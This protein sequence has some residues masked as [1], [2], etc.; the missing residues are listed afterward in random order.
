MPSTTI[1]ALALASL[2]ILLSA[3]STEP[4]AVPPPAPSEAAGGNRIYVASHG[5]HTGFILPADEVRKAIPEFR[6]R[7]AR[8]DFIEIG[9]GDKGFYQ[10]EEITAALTLRAVFWPTE[11][12]AHAVAIPGDPVEFFPTSEVEQLSLGDAELSSLLRF[13]SGSLRRDGGG[14]IVPMGKGL[15]GDS[16]FYGGVGDYHLFNGC[17]KWTAKG[18]QSAGMGISPAF[19]LTA[20]SV[21]RAARAM[22]G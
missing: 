3:C 7:F 21:M 12:V 15:Y 1:P 6:R 8:A 2:A 9:W 4:A 17:N 18:L 19:K 14:A 16:Q 13:V 22:G 11:S 5:W 20:G 10:A